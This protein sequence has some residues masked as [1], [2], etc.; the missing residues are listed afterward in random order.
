LSPLFSNIYLSD[1][2]KVMKENY[3]DAFV[4]YVDDFLVI[5]KT[6]A[7]AREAEKLATKLLRSEGLE[8][9][10]D[11]T[12]VK[13]LK[14]ERVIF[15]GIGIDKDKISTKKSK[16]DYLEEFR[17]EVFGMKKYEKAHVKKSKLISLINSKV[18]GRFNYYKYYHVENIFTEINKIVAQKQKEKPKFKNLILLKMSELKP[19]ISQKSWQAIFH[20]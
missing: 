4:R 2:D 17:Q 6:E 18:L 3:G 19:V 20:K 13:D 12:G 16:D 1:F 5:C 8:V 7:E 14:K 9:A 11:K 15:L 10:P